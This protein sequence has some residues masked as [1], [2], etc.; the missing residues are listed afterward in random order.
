MPTKIVNTGGVRL[1]SRQATLKATGGGVSPAP[2]GPAPPVLV[3]WL[4]GDN[5]AWQDEAKTTPAVADAAPVYWVEGR[6]GVTFEVHTTSPDANRPT[7]RTAVLNGH[8]VFRHANSSQSFR[9]EDVPFAGTTHTLYVVFRATTPSPHTFN[10]VQCGAGNGFLAQK[11][12]NLR[13]LFY[14]GA[15]LFLE[16]GVSTT[17]WELWTIRK[18]STPLTTFHVNGVT[19]AITNSSAEYTPPATVTIIG[20]NSVTGPEVNEWAEVRLYDGAHSDTT[21]SAIEAELLS[22][23]AL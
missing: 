4:R 20:G 2:P 23:Y 14:S 13:Q 1:G 6:E 22:Y 18:D 9:Q 12:V 19:Q 17:G 8:N 21:V 16:D 7:L 15:A 5:I 3:L 10:P 11:T